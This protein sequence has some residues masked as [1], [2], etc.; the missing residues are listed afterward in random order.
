MTIAEIKN[1]VQKLSID[2]QKELFEWVD[3]LRE[4]QWDKQIEKDLEAGKLDHL[5]AEAKKE[6]K[7]GKCQKI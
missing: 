7:E 4:N 5:I 1:A 3:E 6:F 2:E